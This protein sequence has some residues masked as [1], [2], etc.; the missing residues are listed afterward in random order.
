VKETLARL[1]FSFAA[2]MAT[3][4]LI[5]SL[6]GVLWEA[7]YRRRPLPLPAS[8]L[9]DPQ[10]RLAAV[11]QGPVDIDQLL[12]DVETLGV[13]DQKELRD[14]AVPFPGRW[15]RDVFVTNPMAIAGLYLEG[16]YP[17]DA[18][19]HLLGYLSSQKEPPAGAKDLPDWNL[20]ISDVHLLLGRIA[21]GEGK[22]QEAVEAYQAA[23]RHRPG[24]PPAANN[25]AW[26][27][28][29][30]PDAG[31]RNGPEALRLARAVCRSSGEKEAPPLDTLAA[32]CAEVGDFPEALRAAAK[33]LDLARARGQARMA[34][35]IEK[36]IV[37]YQA[38]QP[39]R[40]ARGSERD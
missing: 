30:H 13:T 18:R 28:A 14:L 31:L 12:R 8:F 24:F 2:G 36:R 40:E 19:E 3:P 37:L 22:G 16:G 9:I 27:R 32:A 1:G 17:E 15:S 6:E 23:L 4:E 33:A 25:L 7:I 38:G 34:S 35:E 20:R 39:F 21:Q 29:T 10:R 5:E 11:Y 26:I